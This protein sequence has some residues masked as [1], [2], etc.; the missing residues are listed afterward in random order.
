M[1]LVVILD[2][3]YMTRN[4]SHVGE[5]FM[6]YL[7]STTLAGGLSS[8]SR[9]SAF[10]QV[11]SPTSSLFST[12][13]APAADGRRRILTVTHG[14]GNISPVTYFCIGFYSFTFL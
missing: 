8:R 6:R 11:S 14:I 13:T 9:H 4:C 2:L 5:E 1:H 12:S 10:V 7:L 3:L